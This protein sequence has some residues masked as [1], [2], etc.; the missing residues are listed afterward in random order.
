MLKGS[1][2]IGSIE[3]LEN[4]PDYGVPSEH[5]EGFI[6]ADCVSDPLTHILFQVVRLAVKEN[7]IR[8]FDSTE[9]TSIG[10]KDEEL[11]GKRVLTIL[12]DVSLF[13][14][15]NAVFLPY[16]YLCAFQEKF[17]RKVCLF[18]D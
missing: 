18:R 11:G 3:N 2:I 15:F 12:S 17:E 14:H 13:S 16:I 6:N 7:K 4:D 9:D 8:G 1:D 5:C 10:K